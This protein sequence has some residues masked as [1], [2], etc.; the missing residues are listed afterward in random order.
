MDYLHFLRKRT[1][2]ISQ[3]YVDATSP[4]IERKRKIEKPDAD[5]GAT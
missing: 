3:F 4:F 2:F 5:G 1:D